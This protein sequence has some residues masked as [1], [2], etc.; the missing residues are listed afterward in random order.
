MGLVQP[1]LVL[2]FMVPDGA[3]VAIDLGVMDSSGSRRRIQMST[4]QRE[5]AV[6]PLNARV[7]LSGVITGQVSSHAFFCSSVENIH[8]HTFSYRV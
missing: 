4:S 7:P 1:Y 2:Q 8:F 6:T 3:R 5:M